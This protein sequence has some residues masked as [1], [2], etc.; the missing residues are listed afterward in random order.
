ML[1]IAI[2]DDDVLC[3]DVV[4]S[5]VEK[6][7]S[8]GAFLPNFEIYRYLSGE[9]LLKEMDIR[10]DLIFLDYQMTGLS[11]YDTAKRI[12]EVNKEV[13][14]IFL[15]GFEEHWRKGYKVSAYRYILKP[16]VED[17]FLSD[18]GDVVKDIMQY[19]KIL[20]FPT[21]QGMVD[22]PV[23]E[24]LYAESQKR[25]IDIHMCD[26]I[27]K[28]KI[29]INDAE[30]ILTQYGFVRPHVS[31]CVNMKYISAIG[32]NERRE[33][34]ML[35]SNGDRIHIPRDRKKRTMEEL[36]KYKERLLL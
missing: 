6:F 33:S 13:R 8:T 32:K 16:I 31:Y 15:T 9:E 22:I 19:K 36:L 14:L 12:R 21:Q 2:V 35:L 30:K 4:K 34:Y 17:E 7:F 23:S 1:K 26:K 25:H 18:L 3:I 20:S 29:G 28:S 24:I 10:F 5:H 11:G 27:V